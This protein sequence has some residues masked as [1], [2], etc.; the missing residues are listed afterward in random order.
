M[1]TSG[2]AASF[3]TSLGRSKEAEEGKEREK[4]GN[5]CEFAFGILCMLPFLPQI[6]IWRSHLR[7]PS[8]GVLANF[9]AGKLFGTRQT[10]ETQRNIKISEHQSEKEL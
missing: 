9:P 1:G 5:K 2:A 6:A 7:G 8:T 4:R 3:C 10:E